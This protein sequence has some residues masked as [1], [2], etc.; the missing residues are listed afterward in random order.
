M[1]SLLIWRSLV[2]FSTRSLSILTEEL[3]DDDISSPLNGNVEVP[4]YFLANVVYGDDNHQHVDE[5]SE[6]L[7]TAATN[8]SIVHSPCDI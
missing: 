6:R 2:L 4:V 5:V 3:F 1:N 8:R 7:L